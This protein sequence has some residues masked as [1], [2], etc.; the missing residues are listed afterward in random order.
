VWS[1]ALADGAEPIVA[2]AT[3]DGR[4]ALAVIR[5]SGNGVFDC[6]LSRSRGFDP[7]LAWRVQR[8]EVFDATGRP[9]D[10][11]LASAFPGPRSS[12]G[13]DVVELICHGSPFLV[14][15]ILAAL[16]SAGARPAR[17]GEFTR[18]A[19]A[20][21]KL[22]LVQAE[23]LR[24][25]IGAETRAQA[26]AARRQLEG[27]LSSRLRGL[28]DQLRDLLACLEGGVD[29]VGQGVELDEEAAVA[30]AGWCE[31]E[32]DRLL[33]TADAGQRLRR[34]ARVAILGPPNAGKSTLF[35]QL[36]GWERAIV[37]AVPG[38]TRDAIEC[39]LE[40]GGVVVTLVDTAGQRE[41]GDE[42]E[43][44]GMRHALREE[45]EADLK[46]QLWPV[47]GDVEPPDLD[48]R[49]IGVRSKGDLRGPGSIDAAGW[50]PL[51]A[52]SGAGVEAIRAEIARRLL[53]GVSADDDGVAIGARHRD[54]LERGRR[55]LREF[56]VDLPEVGAEVVREALAAVREMTGEVTTE[57]VLD[58]VF[59][60]FCVG[61]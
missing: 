30:R 11:V 42:I 2:R 14:E 51:S 3:P 41:S 55:A 13:E 39:R 59:A 8:A 46:L 24:D 38:T 43:S 37:S 7:T 16:V 36:V 44:A 31:M 15:S 27:R 22:D 25:L 49:T 50:T 58:A 60:T 1:S 21:G 33:A 17:P 18:R 40:I 9:I 28:R 54:G 61:K 12:T 34:G 52:I 10:T 6:L 45:A 20:N 56:R 23:A 32:I 29:L 53:N 35:N 19:V 48:E 4:G 47:D 5:C 57:D 26:D